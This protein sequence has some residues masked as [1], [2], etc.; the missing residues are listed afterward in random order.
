MSKIL[1][2]IILPLVNNWNRGYVAYLSRYCEDQSSRPHIFRRPWKVCS[3][4]SNPDFSENYFP[5][6][7][8]VYSLLERKNNTRVLTM[9]TDLLN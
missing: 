2:G 6:M 7:Y 9:R 1:V 3:Y 8:V 5:G 4:S